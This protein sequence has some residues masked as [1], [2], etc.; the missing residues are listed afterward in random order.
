LL[1][2]HSQA[3][4]VQKL[5]SL[6]KKRRKVSWVWRYTLV[7]P[8]LRQEDDEFEATHTHDKKAGLRC[9]KPLILANWEAE[10][11]KIEVR[12]QPGQIGHETSYPK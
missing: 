12:G 11:R 6:F 5:S 7:I 9:L 10:I 2:S 1:L 4:D 3:E 8:A